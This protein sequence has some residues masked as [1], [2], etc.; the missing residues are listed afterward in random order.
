M[1]ILAFAAGSSS[2]SINRQ[3]VGYAASMLKQDPVEIIDI[4]DFEMPLY[5]EDREEELNGQLVNA[6]Q[7]LQLLA[8]A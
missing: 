8:A 5:S 7:Q 3:L 1:N 2:K 6:M 4:N